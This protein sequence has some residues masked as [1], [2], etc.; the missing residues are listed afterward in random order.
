V[1]RVLAKISEPI[2]AVPEDT[3]FHM[4]EDFEQIPDSFLELGEKPN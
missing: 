1:A 3:I 4:L 2:H